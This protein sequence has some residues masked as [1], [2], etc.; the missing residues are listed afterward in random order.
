MLSKF[1]ANIEYQKLFS[2]ADYLLVAVSGGVDSVVLCNLLKSGGFSFGIAHANFGLRG[3]ASDEDEQFVKDMATAMNVSF[4]STNFNTKQY[5]SEQ[6]ISTQMAARALRYEWFNSL[7][8]SH[9]YTALV[10]AHHLDDSI[11]TALLN[12]IKGSGLNGIK[13]I[14]EKNEFRT[15][16]LV[17]FTKKEIT[18]YAIANQIKW[19]EDASN[20]TS[21]YERN[22]IRHDILPLFSSINGSYRNT[23]AGSIRK[24]STVHEH[25]ALL[26]NEKLHPQLSYPYKNVLSVTTAEW[27]GKDIFPNILFLLEGYGFKLSELEKI[28][29]N[30]R[31]NN[32]G[33]I[34][35]S[36]TYALNTDR[37]RFV[38]APIALLEP[39]EININSAEDFNTIT[40]PCGRVMSSEITGKPDD[41]VLKNSDK[42]VAWFSSE[43]LKFPLVLRTWK[44]GDSFIP[45]GMDKRKKISDLLTEQK[46]SLIEKKLQTVLVQDSEIVWVTG[47]RLSSLYKVNASDC[48]TFHLR[49]V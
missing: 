25:Y 8:I 33:K 16:P 20:A 17:H 36:D 7:R 3:A 21:D 19:R 35:Y 37:G 2:K 34:H 10:T 38:L 28:A 44:E 40:L 47:I 6:G 39:V 22:F 11:E 26:M 15:S 43:K 13:G 4:H 14:A 31:T 27:P 9:N 45:L 18:E 49:I 46:L 29:E 41:T 12:F 1:I 42:N 48:Q 24:L 5:A 32:T 30:I 23:M